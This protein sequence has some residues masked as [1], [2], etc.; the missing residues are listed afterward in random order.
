MNTNNEILTEVLNLNKLLETNFYNEYDFYLYRKFLETKRD[1]LLQEYMTLNMRVY[2]KMQ[3]TE[4]N[5]EK[6]INKNKVVI[7]RDKTAYNPNPF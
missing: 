4:L 1:E 7:Q 6:V 3:D 2:K 5:K